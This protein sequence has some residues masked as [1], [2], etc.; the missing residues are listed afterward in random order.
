MKVNVLE[1]LEIAR[2]LKDK[3]ATLNRTRYTALAGTACEEVIHWLKDETE[4][5]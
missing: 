2:Q 4:A 5:E 1:A 3:L